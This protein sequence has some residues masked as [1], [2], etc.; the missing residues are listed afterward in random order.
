ME[1][2]K[3]WMKGV[4]AAKEKATSTHRAIVTC[5]TAPEDRSHPTA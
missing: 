3:K 5:E 4:V 1:K 2:R